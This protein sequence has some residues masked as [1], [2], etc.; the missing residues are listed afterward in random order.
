M[1]AE[2]LLEKLIKLDCIY[3]LIGAE[4]EA[5]SVY[6]SN[7][8][9]EIWEKRKTKIQLKLIDQFKK[10]VCEKQKKIC[11]EKA[12]IDSDYLPAK[13]ELQYFIEPDSILNAPEPD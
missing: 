8:V 3:N 9:F 12:E 11:A 6:I 10:E 1:K 2:E 7:N 4:I 5:Y 13:D